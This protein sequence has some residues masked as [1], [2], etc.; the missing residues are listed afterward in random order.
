MKL[1]VSQSPLQSDTGQQIT[2]VRARALHHGRRINETAY[3]LH[4][5]E[6]KVLPQGQV[7]ALGW[8]HRLRTF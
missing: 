3:W 1:G 4:L 5:S 6:A 2:S 7:L 8:R